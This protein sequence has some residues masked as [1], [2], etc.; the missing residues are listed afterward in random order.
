MYIQSCINNSTYTAAVR[1]SSVCI[2]QRTAVQLA[3]W[4]ASA[5]AHAPRFVLRSL[6][7]CRCT[8]NTNTAVLWLVYLLVHAKPTA[9]TILK[10]RT[11]W[12]DTDTANRQQTIQ[13]KSSRKIQTLRIYWCGLLD[14]CGFL[15]GSIDEEHKN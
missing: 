14:F 15:Q 5:H 11:T 1:V 9:T 13:K 3:C 6:G 8:T 2:Q 10:K 7:S 4:C 12:N